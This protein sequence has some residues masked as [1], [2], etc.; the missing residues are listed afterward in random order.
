MRIALLYNARAGEGLSGDSLREAHERAGHVVSRVVHTDVELDRALGES[1]DLVVAAGGDGTVRRAAIA[2]A[3]TGIPLA[4]L[5][6][7]TA[8]NIA[9]S[10]GV[11]GTIPELIASWPEARCVPLDLGVVRGKFG[12]SRFLE[13]VGSGLVAAGI[14]AIQP[15]PDDEKDVASR[16]E[17]AVREYLTLLS[18]LGPRFAGLDMDG[19][20]VDGEFLLVEVLNTSAIGPN[21]VLSD[22]AHAG[23]GFL[24]VVVAEEEHREELADYLRCRIDGSRCRVCLPT[25][26]ARRVVIDGCEEMHVDDEV[27]RAPWIGTVSIEVE[28]GAVRFLSTPARPAS[29]SSVTSEADFSHV[30]SLD[31]LRRV[32]SA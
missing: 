6:L 22:D 8:N 32:L 20:R 7:G 10:L 5:P 14:A 30:S 25:C 15:V 11:E 28:A 31:T 17:N 23:D 3:G 13:S 26:R 16:L 12:E 9:L 1:P 29:R 21:L 27:H 4:I 19:R 18:R 24:S 2:L